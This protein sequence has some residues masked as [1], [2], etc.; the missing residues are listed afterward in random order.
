MTKEH[1][2]GHVFWKALYMLKSGSVR[3]DDVARLAGVSVATVSRALSNPGRVKKETVAIVL[4]AVSKLG[5]VAHGHARALAS[6]KSRTIGAVIPSLENAIF[7]NTIYALQKVLGEHGYMLVVA[8][9]EYDLAVEVERVRGLIERGV[10]GLVLTQTMHLPEIFSL[11]ERFHLPHVFTWAY[12]GDGRLPAVGFDNRRATSHA[13]RHM[14]ELG[15]REIGVIA[16]VTKDNKNAQERL[17]GVVDTLAAAGIELPPDRI[18]EAPFSFAKGR[19]ALRK[20]MESSR[21]PTAIVCLND[22]LAIGA[23]AEAREIGLDVPRDLS[24]S[25]CEDL[26]VASCVTP[27]LTTVRYP[28]WE[29]GHVAGSY[30]LAL[31]NKGEP[32]AQ[33]MFPTHLVVR[34]STAPPAT[35]RRKR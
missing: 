9:S 29:M 27:P 10:D 31:L 6:R 15:H 32:P 33:R 30:L 34:G 12:D 20:L 18:V 22:V 28:T 13:T 4:D 26:E 25:G 2:D 5:Y 1:A 14:L 35:V 11:L 3:I 19:E 23:M 8:C 17:G 24:I 21:R 7:A 16:T